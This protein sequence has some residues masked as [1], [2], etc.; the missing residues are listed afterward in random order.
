[1]MAA[2]NFNLRSWNSNCR[3]VP[4]AA[5]S[6]Q[7]LDKDK[8][9][10]ILGMRWDAINDVITFSVR[11]IP[12]SDLITKRE[13]LKHT[14]ILYDPLGLLTPVTIRAKIML[15]ELWQ[16]KYSWDIPLPYDIQ[17]R[18]HEIASDINCV[19][20]EAFDRY[21]LK[22]DVTQNFATCTDD[23]TLHV[24]V[25]ASMA[26]YE[27]A[28]YICRG[29]KSALVMSKTRVAP[30]KELTL[31]R[32][33]LMAAVIAA[34]LVRHLLWEVAVFKVELWSD[35]QITL[36]WLQTTKRLQRFV[37][38]RVDTINKLTHNR[39]WKYYPT[40]ENPADLLTRGIR[41]NQFTNNVLWSKGPKWIT[42]AKK[43][44][45]WDSVST[46]VCTMCT[47][48]CHEREIDTTTSTFS[49]VNVTGIHNVIKVTRYSKLGKL[50]R[51]TAYVLRFVRNCMSDKSTI[52]LEPF[53]IAE[54]KEEDHLWIRSSQR[55]SYKEEI[56]NM[57]S[58]ESRLP[59]VK[60][61]KLFIDDAGDIQCCGR[62]HN[63][64][65]PENTMFPYLLSQKHPYTP[66]VVQEMHNRLFHSGVSATIT[67]LIQKYWIPT[68]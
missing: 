38:N 67:Y 4:E 66:L 6:D 13:V 43:W 3:S 47:E 27:A 21:L 52:R 63:A 22:N 50:L 30:L 24:F 29:N 61:L 45:K 49:S 17:E 34:R 14:A 54:L 18:W 58:K 56:D 15:Q 8:F 39:K 35:S 9:S 20:S 11:M 37:K 60:Q 28:V 48:D 23:T 10:K 55:T 64:P 65:I 53:T 19:S 40:K 12:I 62:I 46:A 16:K 51:I 59:L 31:P 5:K 41:A 1:M 7:I 25:D 26:A 44:P 42:D 2:A 57:K 32:L 33:E 68:A 36:H